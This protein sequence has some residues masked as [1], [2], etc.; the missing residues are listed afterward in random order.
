MAKYT[1]EEIKELK[2]LGFTN[3]QIVALMGGAPKV[4]EAKKPTES[5]APRAKKTAE[6][7]EA[8]KK[9]RAEA[10]K[11]EKKAW[12]EEHYTE[13]ERKAFKEERDAR[14]AEAKKKHL[15]YC[16]TNAHF[17]GKKVSKEDWHKK[18][19][20]YLKKIG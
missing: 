2:E 7:R 8:E 11:A 10:W 15:A 13:A 5:K 19:N 17:G 18:Y 16:Q 12:A 20:E 4:S 1:I 6:E 9:A 14:R 3:E